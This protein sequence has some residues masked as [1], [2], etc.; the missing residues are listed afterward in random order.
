MSRKTSDARYIHMMHCIVLQCK[1]ETE[2]V[3]TVSYS[4]H[5]RAQACVCM[6]ELPLPEP[7]NSRRSL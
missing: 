2:L 5:L 3:N 4:I 1:E 7:Q 6:C